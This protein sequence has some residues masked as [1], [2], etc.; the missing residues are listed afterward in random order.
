MRSVE[1]D[2]FL[3]DSV[4]ASGGKLHALGLGWRAIVVSSLPARHDR[5]GI[6]VLVRTS[7]AESGPHRLVLSLLDP[8]GAARP[9]GP[10]RT[11]LEAAFETPAGEGSATLALNLDGLVFETEGEHTFVLGID[12]RQVARLAFR[13]QT[14]P[15]PPSAEVRGGLYL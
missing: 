8:G 6:G 7:A 3:A 2:A 14:R 5:V 11:S 12:D 10:D 4:Q 1:V 13:I 15:E 9:F